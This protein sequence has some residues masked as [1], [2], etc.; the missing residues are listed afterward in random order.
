MP[1]LKEGNVRIEVK[2][3]NKVSKQDLEK[4]IRKS[5]TVLS[6]QAHANKKKASGVKITKGSIIAKKA[7]PY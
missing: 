4:Y 5:K 3:E 7:L 2:S 1:K 6:G